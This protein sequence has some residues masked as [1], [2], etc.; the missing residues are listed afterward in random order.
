MVRSFIHFDLDLIMWHYKI[1]N[2]VSDSSFT[3]RNKVDYS[4][5]IQQ[6]HIDRTLLLIKLPLVFS[7]I[8]G[9]TFWMWL[10]MLT[11]F[12]IGIH[13]KRI[14]VCPYLWLNLTVKWSRCGILYLYLSTIPLEGRIFCDFTSN[15]SKVHIGLD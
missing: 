10:T 9:V 12:L 6:Q 4:K 5:R 1:G 7:T 3:T 13:S 2:L 11:Q 15:S 14:Y 8:K